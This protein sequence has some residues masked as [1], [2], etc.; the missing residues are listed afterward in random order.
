MRIA[1]YTEW[2]NIGGSTVALTDL[3]NLI[4]QETVHRVKIFCPRLGEDSFI[5]SRY[6]E[7]EYLEHPLDVDKLKRFKPDF[8]IA[9]A[10]GLLTGIK[11]ERLQEVKKILG[12]PLFIKTAHEAKFIDGGLY[13][14]NPYSDKIY[15][16]IHFV[17][18]AQQLDYMG[19]KPSFV[20]PNYVPKIE[21]QNTKPIEGLVVGIIGSM[22]FNKRTHLSIA[23]ANSL[24]AKEIILFGP[25]R[26]DEYFYKKLVPA[27]QKSKAPVKGFGYA[28]REV[29]YSKVNCVVSESASET[30][31]LVAAECEML[32]IPYHGISNHTLLPKGKIIELWEKELNGLS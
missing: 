31:N 6:S 32:D 13:D 15:D 30:F 5:H 29:I 25:L 20:I 19:E 16:K 7:V 24:G 21:L 14:E 3:A 12:N 9:H 8:V 26:Q 10:W 4:Q 28:E 22:D 17:S 11:Q 27:I 23:K 2:P 18:E 1:L